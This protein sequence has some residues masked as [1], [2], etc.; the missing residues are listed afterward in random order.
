[1]TD[2]IPDVWIGLFRQILVGVG[3][4]L[5]AKYGIDAVTTGGL[6]EAILA[7]AG[8]LFTFGSMG[9]MVYTRAGTRAVT[10]T[11]AARADVP[12]ISP[13]TGQRER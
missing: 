1:M 3:T 4:P 11:T 10:V 13:V 7:A 9:W 6:V 12:T 8:A 2:R 5:M